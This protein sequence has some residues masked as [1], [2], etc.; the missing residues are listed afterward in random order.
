MGTCLHTLRVKSVEGMVEVPAEASRVVRFGRGG[1]GREYRVDLRVGTYDSEVSR[2]QGELT[3]RDRQWWLQKVGQ[4]RF[5]LPSDLSLYEKPVNDGSPVP[6]DVGRTTH[7]YV[8]GSK[9]REYELE[10]FVFDEEPPRWT[11]YDIKA[12]QPRQWKLSDDERLVLA[13]A[14]E[15]YLRGEPD[16]RPLTYRDA[17]LRLD[18]LDLGK[19][20]GEKWAVKRRD[21]TRDKYIEALAKKVEHTL[22]N[23][24]KR[25]AGEDFP[26][27]L[28]RKRDDPYDDRLKHNLLKG[29]TDSATLTSEDLDVFEEPMAGT[30]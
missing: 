13:V 5:R 29:L 19:I 20:W 21:L 16:P 18:L 3:Y 8:V 11:P 22:A 7:V 10:V 25:L 17:A 24:R 28:L 6:L 4:S 27:Q 14:A 23:V 15:N 1:S 30:R 12:V 2:R 26:R 9:S